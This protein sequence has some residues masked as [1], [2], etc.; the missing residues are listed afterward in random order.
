MADR[1][2]HRVPLAE[3]IARVKTNDAI[4]WDQFVVLRCGG[5]LPEE[6]RIVSEGDEAV[7]FRLFQVA[8]CQR[9]LEQDA[10]QVYQEYRERS[11]STQAA[12]RGTLGT[13]ERIEGPK[14]VVLI[15]EGL[16]TE[17]PGE[18][19]D[20]GVLA[21]RAQVTLFVVLLDSSSADA[22]FDYSALATQEDREA[23]AAGLYDLAG[24]Q[25]GAVLRVV[26]SPGRPS[27]GSRELAGCTPAG[28]RSRRPRRRGQVRVRVSRPGAGPRPGSSRSS[29]GDPESLAAALR[30][31]L[32]DAVCR[33]G[34]GVRVAGPA[35]K[36]ASSS[37]HGWVGRPAP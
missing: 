14:T 16:G 18:L 24:Q 10:Q 37:R 32:V 8:N 7:P 22:S 9:D 21:S 12:L 34:H 19:R 3:A 33:A 6:G 17:S 15:S 13:L 30:S 11:L 20:L 2:G 1:G 35:K 31:P 23:E 36:V 29:P 27:S 25:R 26:G 5:S 4:R 28:A